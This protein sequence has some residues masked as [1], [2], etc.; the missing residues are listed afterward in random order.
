MVSLEREALTAMRGQG[1]QVHAVSDAAAERWRTVGNQGIQ[2]IL[3]K[4]IPEESYDLVVELVSEHS[5]QR[6]RTE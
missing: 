6:L 2:V 1:L 3:G 4:M 5:G